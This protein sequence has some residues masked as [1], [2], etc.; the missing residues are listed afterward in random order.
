VI[1][2]GANVELAR[3]EIVLHGQL[4]TE[5]I[6]ACEAEGMEERLRTMS[7]GD[8][9]EALDGLTPDT[10]E[11]RLK[12]HCVKA[13]KALLYLSEPLKD[14]CFKCS[15]DE[16]VFAH[17]FVLGTQCQC[18][19]KSSFLALFQHIAHTGPCASCADAMRQRAR[20]SGGSSLPS[21]SVDSD[22]C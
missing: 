16:Y 17:K 9:Q 14:V 21:C 20:A 22:V 15:D 8:L 2:L 7:M 19:P 3:R 4:F 1:R 10:R 12:A 13:T 5:Y 18:A 11:E 6:A